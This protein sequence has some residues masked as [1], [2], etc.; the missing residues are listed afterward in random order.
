M[1]RVPRNYVQTSYFHVMTQGLNKSYIFEYSEDI[2]YYINNMHALSEELNISIIAFCIMNN[3]AHLLLKVNNLKDLSKYMQRLNTRFGMYYNN[4]YDRVGYVFRD[5]YRAEGI[6]S[7]VQ[8]YNC[9]KYIHDNP[10]KAGICN[11][12]SEYP[13]SSYKKESHNFQVIDYDFIDLFDY[14]VSSCKHAIDVF[15]NDNHIQLKDLSN[16]M[17]TLKKLVILLKERYHISL[18][19]ISQEL[20]INREYIRKI[21]K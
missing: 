6:Y 19:H 20:N 5:R 18:R 17:L 12:A 9:I 21:Y 11:N 10:V 15:L 8:L 14:K 13:Y 3:H 4:K 1:P 7:D 2:L 16:D